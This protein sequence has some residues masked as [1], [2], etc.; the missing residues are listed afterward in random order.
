MKRLAI[1]LILAVVCVTS[2]FA[3]N[4]VTRYYKQIKIVTADKREQAG[5]GGG[6]FIYFNEMGCYDS[7]KD[8]FDVKNGFLAYKGNAGG[9]HT[10]YGDSY[11]GKATYYFLNDY[12][13]LNIVVEQG[14]V[15]YVYELAKPPANVTTSAL[16]KNKVERKPDGN[17]GSTVVIV[18]PVI[19]V[20]HGVGNQIISIGS[21][22]N[23]KVSSKRT[24]PGCNGTGNGPEEIIY[25]PNYTG[26]NSCY[27]STCG[28]T[29]SC[30][31]HRTTTCKVCYGKGYV[32]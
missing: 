21:D 16:T 17:P 31:T 26:S 2:L 14:G 8:G 9:Y 6:Q 32:D 13:R 3:G 20:D 4:R 24:C 11:W 28:R 19:P 10:Y 12:S 23:S 5:N 27:C 22:N 30:H 25:Q 18:D 1:V 29:G 7:D 15:T